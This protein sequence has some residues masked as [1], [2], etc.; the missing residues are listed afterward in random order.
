M[1][2]LKLNSKPIANI[3]NIVAGDKYRITVLTPALVRLEYCNDGVFEDGATQTVLNR[4]FPAVDYKLKEEKE[5]LEIETENIKLYYNKKEFSQNGLKIQIYG[6][7]M[8]YN[9]DWYYGKPSDSLGGTART[10]DNV[11]GRIA[12]EDGVIGR[13]GFAV[14]DDSKSLRITDTYVE[15]RKNG[16]DLYVFCYGHEYRRAIKDFYYLCG[17][18]PLLPRFALGNW[19]SRYYRYSEDSYTKLMDDF[20]NEKIPFSVAV[21]DMDWHL[22]EIDKKYGSGWTGYTWNKELF[23]DYKRFLKNLHDRGMS[24]TLNV[25]PA[26]G[27]RAY[28]DCYLRIAEHMG[29]DVANEEKVE[30]DP[31]NEKFM[32]CYFN[33]VHH[34][35]EMDG[36]D[37]WWVDWQQGNNSKIEGLDP[38]WMLNHYHFLDNGRDGKRPLTFSRYAGPGSH[39]YPVGFSGDTHITWESLDF[40]P[41]FTT[42]ASNIGYGWWSHDI[43]GHMLGNKDNELEL[44]WYQFGVFSP[45][46]R[47]HS[48]CNDFCGKE[49]WNFPVEIHMVMNEFLRLRHRMIPYL[50]TMNY[51]S[52]MGRPLMSPMYYDYPEE[53]DAYMVGNQ[54]Y[55]GT[56]L[57]VA[58]ITTPNIKGI[59][60]AK[61]KV[62]LPEGI[63]FDIFTHTVY[64][65]GRFIN[66]YRDNSSIPVLAKAGAIIPLT[67]EITGKEF[68]D[69]PRELSVLVYPGKDN[70][71]DMYEDDG[72]TM[73][74]LEGKIVTT[75]FINN[76][77]E[78]KFVVRKPEGEMSLIPEKRN[79]QLRFCCTSDNEVE[80]YIGEKIVSCESRYDVETHTFVVSVDNWDYSD[81]IIVV[82]KN[83]HNIMKNAYEKKIFNIL[84]NAEISY[85]QKED[86]YRP[87]RG[88]RDLNYIISELSGRNIDLEI[89]DAVL[90]QLLAMI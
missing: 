40:Q 16:E 11:N 82:L 3:K 6:T 27:V 17:A 24:V 41:Y 79:I 22:V 39:R 56:E 57:L 4:N 70:E 58:P 37:F 60:C 89:R 21:I 80:V 52:S 69:N 7:N 28:E 10:L 63:Y 88:G 15:P 74:Y 53:W 67:D 71:F 64:T 26:D 19:W 65:G 46:M 13:H 29:V 59:N 45:I 61:V 44:R 47:L 87:I 25:H 30:F 78:G 36:V 42:T 75:K 14:L 49:P 55:F 62:W 23:P 8:Q 77:S 86:I 38:L 9:S 85:S 48:S 43:G 72:K 34:P 54:Y 81:D 76:Y 18:T 31:T 83:K 33:D 68:L 50:Y 51:I 12:L 5:Y 66:M 1:N 2:N 20:E 90:E 32:E 35:L 84:N 73:D